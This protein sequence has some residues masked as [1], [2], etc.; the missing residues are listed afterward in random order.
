MHMATDSPATLLTAAHGFYQFAVPQDVFD[1]S[2]YYNLLLQP[3]I[4]IPDHYL[5]YQ[6]SFEF[7]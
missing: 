5:L 4:A 2:L 7:R 6:E 3:T 1:R